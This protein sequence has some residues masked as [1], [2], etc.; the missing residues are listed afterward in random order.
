MA[1]SATSRRW[2]IYLYVPNLIGYARILINITAFA[3]CFSHK[4]LFVALYFFSF[5]CDYFD[6]R[7]AQLLNQRSTF[8][9]VLDMVTDRVSTAALLVI[10]SHLFSNAYL[11]FVGL[12]ALD[13]SSHWLQ[14]YSTFLSNKTSHKDVN[15][16]KSLLLRLYYQ[17]RAV[18]GYCAIGAEVLYLVLYLL[19]DGSK[20]LTEVVLTAAAEKSVLFYVGLFA[21]PG[22][23]IKQ[24][25]NLV[26][27][28]SAADLCVVHDLQKPQQKSS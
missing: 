27:M 16:S 28:K 25:V 12:L 6:G 18:M 3:I 11:L 20:D 10:L 9:A 24:I 4:A 8:G 5:V 21:F 13:I 23:V 7:F 2:P 22:C 1:A 17:Y 19:G 14:M 26:Q 15:D